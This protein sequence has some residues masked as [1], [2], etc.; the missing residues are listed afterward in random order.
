VRLFVTTAS[1]PVRKVRITM[2][3]LGLQDKIDIIQTRWPHTWGTNTVPF[4]PDF[5][6]AT[7][8]GR[9]PALM[10]EDGIQLTDSSV[11]CDYLNAEFGEY[12][13][14]PRDGRERW[15]IQSVA[16]LASAVLEAQAARRAETLRKKSDK[17]SEY[18]AD[19]ERKMIERQVRCYKTLNAMA[20]EFREQADLGQIATAAACGISDFRFSEDPWRQENP[21]LAAWYDM[22]RRRPSMVATEPAE[23]P[24]TPDD[25]ALVVN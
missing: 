22:F 6:D 24:T 9:I 15:K 3:E 2:F 5:A 20:E 16:W 1:G 10:T 23:T 8:V 7:P 18:S 19:F 21:Q 14:C 4:R 13:L 12:R 11:I 17:P 25:P